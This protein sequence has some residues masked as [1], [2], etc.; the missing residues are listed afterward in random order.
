[1]SI[2]LAVVLFDGEGKAVECY[3]DARDRTS[4]RADFGAAPAWT[5]DVGFV[6][7]HHGGGLLMR[8][9]FAGHYVDVDES[10]HVS[11]KGTAEGA[12]SG[13]IL[14]L[15]I[16]PPGIAVG[17]LAGALIGGQTGVASDVEAEPQALAAQLRDAIPTSSSAIVMFAP[18]AEIDEVL[19]LLGDSAKNV[20][21]REL[22]DD[23]VAVLDASLETAP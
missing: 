17:F 9:M 5:R 19:G 1:V 2:E 18:T 8:G 11:Q 10:D 12:V 4:S 20:V 15:V 21:R 16:G 14:G 3:A 7:R 13:A 22:S 6:E 23:D